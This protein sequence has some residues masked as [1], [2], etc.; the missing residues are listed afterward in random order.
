MSGDSRSAVQDRPACISQVFKPHEQGQRGKA[1]CQ[2][3]P[4]GRAS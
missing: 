3:G 4:I 2:T 1:G